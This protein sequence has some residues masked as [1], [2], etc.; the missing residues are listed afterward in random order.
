MKCLCFLFLLIAV[1]LVTL[2]SGTKQLFS[3]QVETPEV[4]INKYLTAVI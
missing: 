1:V 2:Q 3:S 4:V